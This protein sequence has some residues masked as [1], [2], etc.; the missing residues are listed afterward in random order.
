MKK[1]FLIVA[2]IS[3]IFNGFSQQSYYNDVDLDLTGSELKNALS[4]KI[5]QTHTKF[6]QYTPDI[7]NASKVTDA[8]PNN[9]DEVILI[10]GWEA[11][12]DQDDTNDRTRSNSLQDNGSNGSFVWNREHVYPQ[13]LGT[14]DITT[15]TIPGQDAHSLRPVDKP[16]NSSRGNKRFAE[17]SGNS[18][19]S[20]NGWYPGDEWKGDVARMMMYM[21]VRYDDQ[22]LPTNV[23]IGD[24]SLTQDDMIDLFLKWNVDDKVSDIEIARNEYHENTSNS[25]AQGNR[26]PFID[27]PYLATI[28]W[29]GNDNA[30]DL[31]GISSDDDVDPSQPINVTASNRT[32]TTIDIEWDPS[33][34]NV[35]VTGYNIYIDDVLTFQTSNSSFQL[36]DLTPDTQYAIEIEAKD[37]GN[38]KSE[39]SVV[40]NSSTTAD[41]TAPSAPTNITGSNIS[42]TAFKINWDLAEDDTAA[43]GYKVFVNTE[44]IASTADLFYTLTGLTVS[45]TYSITVSAK[46]AADNE[47]EQSV[48]VN[49]TT[50]DGSSNGINELFFSEY[51][52]G[53]G[54]NKAIEIVNLTSSAVDLTGYSI[55]K[56]SN[57][58]GDWIDELSLNSGSVKSITTGDVFVVIN[59]L[60]DSQE[61]NNQA[62]L[63]HPNSSPINWN[64][65]DAVGLFKNGVLIDIVGVLGET[66]KNFADMTLRRVANVTEPN[67]T[68]T[69]SEWDEFPKDNVEDIGSHTSTLSANDAIFNTFKMYPNPTNG[70][71]LYFKTTKEININ[72]YNALGQIVK[73]ENISKN[74]NN[75]DIS[76]LSKGIFIIKINFGSTNISKKLIKY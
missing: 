65:N 76:N 42:G 17:G 10:Y 40:L 60:A 64:G 16:T 21:Y 45:T 33:E 26:N 32:T 18:G 23:G 43:T 6:L 70:N 46:D 36:I 58:A 25:A 11:G 56:Q 44:L 15:S 13:S 73:S 75:I 72:I 19:V 35:G 24:S 48:S 62:D 27:N 57:G 4:T 5:T 3:L 51:V 34:D 37:L 41:I 63:V 22:C 50:T 61:L 8:N 30:E 38:N 28:I 12:N 66:A 71:T 2:F 1:I 47:S 67:S 52:E 59:S 14:P 31:W 68:Y 39:K 69:R 20:N 7:W 9:T 29:G 55:K 74:K 53:G 49:I 54:Y